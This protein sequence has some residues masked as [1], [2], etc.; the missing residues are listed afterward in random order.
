MLASADP[1][2]T[3]ALGCSE[4]YNLF[5]DNNNGLSRLSENVDADTKDIIPTII[6]ENRE[7]AEQ[8]KVDRVLLNILITAK[9]SIE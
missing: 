3:G 9:F 6:S 2:G 4:F 1:T 7:R 8:N 5:F